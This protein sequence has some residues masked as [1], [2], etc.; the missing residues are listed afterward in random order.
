MTS[1]QQRIGDRV[2]CTSHPTLPQQLAHR[3][4][5]K[6]DT[7]RPTSG[8]WLHEPTRPVH[9]LRSIRA[10]RRLNVQRAHPRAPLMWPI[11]SAL[12]WSCAHT[13]QSRCTALDTVARCHPMASRAAAMVDLGV[14]ASVQGSGSERGDE[15]ASRTGYRDASRSWWISHV[16]VRCSL[17]S[18]PKRT[19]RPSPG[20]DNATSV[21]F[22]AGQTGGAAKCSRRPTISCCRRTGLCRGHRF[23]DAHA[24]KRTRRVLTGSVLAGV[25]W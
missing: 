9:L 25:G 24:P 2:S 5:V 14:G 23:A 22:R 3:Q 18:A 8:W 21:V 10:H 17:P 11:Q 12:R 4:C 7:L 6:C 15:T 1:H 20:A 16:Y 19:V 13:D